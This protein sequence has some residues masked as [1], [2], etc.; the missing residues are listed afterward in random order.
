MSAEALPRHRSRVDLSRES[1]RFAPLWVSYLV[2]ITFFLIIAAPIVWLAVTALRTTRNTRTI[3]W[4][5]NLAVPQL[6]RGVAGGQVQ[7][8]RATR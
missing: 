3:R 8:L 5:A 2:M 4:V 1:V 6:R 7:H